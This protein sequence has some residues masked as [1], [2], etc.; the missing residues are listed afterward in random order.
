MADGFSLLSPDEMN[1]A[2]GLL[3]PP[4]GAAPGA[5]PPGLLGPPQAPQMVPQPPPQ[6][7]AMPPPIPTRGPV[8]PILAG[9]DNLLFSGAFQKGSQA[10]YEQKVN[11]VAIQRQYAAMVNYASGLPDAERSLFW[12]DPQGYIK[13]QQGN[14]AQQ[15][16]KANE[17]LV[18][19]R[20]ASTGVLDAPYTAPTM[21]VD[22]KSGRPYTQTPGGTTVT[23]PSFGGD[24]TNGPGNSAISGRTGALQGVITPPENFA[25]PNTYVPTQISGFGGPP[26][27]APL[28]GAPG[29]PTA[30]APSGAQTGVGDPRAFFKSFILPHEGGLNPSDMNGAPTNF[31][32]NQ[33]A[34][35]GVDVKSLTPDSAA[36]IFAN[37]YYGASGAA[38]LPPGLAAIHADTSFI[39]PGK[40]KQFLA[41][42]GGDPAKYMALRQAWMNHMVA[43]NPAAAKY[44]PAWAKR[45][46]DLSQFAGPGAAPGTPG[47]AG[48]PAGAPLIGG[49]GAPG[50][51]A[52]NLPPGSIPGKTA[53]PMSPD[54]ARSMGLAPGRYQRQP[55]GSIG[56][57]SQAP[58]DDVARIASLQ[59]TTQGLRALQQEQQQFIQHN[60][61]VGTGAQNKDFHLFGHDVNPLPLIGEQNPDFNAMKA[62]EGKQLFM[63]KPANAGARIL[64]SE[65]PYWETQTQSID[66]P[67]PVNTQ[68]LQETTQNLTKAQA[69]S[70]FYSDWIY[71]NGN[72]DGADAAWDKQSSP[73]AATQG[74]ATVNAP[75]QLP[76]YTPQQAGALAPGTQFRS[77]D[78][79]ILVKH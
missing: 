5:P 66:K 68:R 52:S 78:G 77:T 72:L 42:S 71:K 60:Y 26:P 24:Y 65:L 45:N 22:D 62:S 25:G 39:N 23:G 9:L 41:Q 33:A 53:Q 74:P 36:D 29:A 47:P 55:D 61:N 48:P 2:P 3:A 17:T 79:R 19:H 51:P 37:K 75:R 46:A 43:T 73:R 13:S 31:G 27:G 76:V 67:G 4:M 59:A 49:G 8:N 16:V 70:N 20:N 30:P 21:G 69:Q 34:N 54:D 35:P 28:I 40:A 10:N 64:Q 18:G 56:V 15:V 7:A 12:N 58:K 63:V 50:S 32:I 1:V 44:G 14:E 11:N 6:D 38:S 57:I